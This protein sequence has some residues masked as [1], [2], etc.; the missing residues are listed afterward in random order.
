MSYYVMQKYGSNLYSL[1]ERYRM[2]F[3]AKTIFQIGIQLVK[4]LQK[5]H[6]AGFTYNDMK[7]DNILVG[8]YSGTPETLHEIRIIDFGFAAKYR[9][10][11]GDHIK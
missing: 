6:Q 8:D 4:I 2:Q 5:V 9:E 7:L 1:F 3:S 11:N 10:A